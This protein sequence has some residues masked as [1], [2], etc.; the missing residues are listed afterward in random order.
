L[1]ELVGVIQK[2]TQNTIQ[3]MK[4]TD[5]ATGTV[6]SVSPLTV[7]S[8]TNTQPLP[9]AALVL[10]DM[11]RDNLSAGDKVLMLRVKNGNQYILLSKVK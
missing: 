9:A 10:T 11:V 7:Q 1:Y 3:A 4:L 6:T 2:I 8:D 5:M